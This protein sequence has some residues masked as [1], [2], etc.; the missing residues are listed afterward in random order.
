MSVRGDQCLHPRT[1]VS[2]DTDL[3]LARGLSRIEIGHVGRHMLRDQ[4]V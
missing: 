4:R 2:L 3:H 1:P